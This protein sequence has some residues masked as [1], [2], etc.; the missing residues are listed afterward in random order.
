MPQTV[1]DLL[2]S[3]ARFGLR[4]LAGPRSETAVRDVSA[5]PSLAALEHAAEGSLAVV[6]GAVDTSGF[7]MDV[8][9]RHAAGRGLAGIVLAQHNGARQTLSVTSRHLAERAQVPVLAPEHPQEGAAL[10]LRIDR[11]VRGGAADT[12][13]RVEA[14]MEACRAAAASETG[15][16]I[17]AV[18]A[19]ASATLGRAVTLVETPPADPRAPGAVVLGEQPVAEVVTAGGSDGATEVVLPAVAALLSRLRQSELNRRYAP[20]MTRAELIVQ[21]VLSERAQLPVLA[22]QA[23]RIGLPVQYTHLA[24]WLHVTDPDVRGADGLA[25]QRRLLGAA[26]LTALQQL[27]PRHG[28]WHVVSFG[29]DLLVVC[30]DRVGAADLHRR[31]RGEVQALIDVLLERGDMAITAGMGTPQAG[32]D[33]IRQS[34]AEAR[35][36]SD[37]AAARGSR[38]TI[39]DTDATGLRRILA[40]LYSSRLSRSLLTELL[41]PLQA[42][43]PERARVGVE[44]LAALLDAQGSPTKAAR[45]LHLHPNAVTYRLQWI[46]EALGVDLADPDAR[47]ALHLACKVRLLD[48]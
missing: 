47:F 42:L 11:Y 46:T 32:A 3:T 38:G 14:T 15:D 39:V 24:V 45:V 16:P 43:G 1:E 13:A 33:G 6:L 23:Q 10:L 34:A 2:G 44:T 21:I 9:I 36:A 7:A 17:A 19:A 29:G 26:E 37:A 40:D 30:T 4:L 28:M 35:V 18:L 12:L 48:G 41:A 27:D 22:E 20:A 25:R 8:A 31:V 5:V